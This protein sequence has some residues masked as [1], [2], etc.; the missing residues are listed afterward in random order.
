MSAVSGDRDRERLIAQVCRLFGWRKDLGEHVIAEDPVG[1]FV[2]HTD[3]VR[4]LAIAQAEALE[5][6]AAHRWLGRVL[7]ERRE[8]V[9]KRDV[10]A[11]LKARAARL[12]AQAGSEE[13]R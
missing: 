1:P 11:W 13:G 9:E 10:R 2:R 12:R 3:H 8:K 7:A 5:E 6:M 4:S